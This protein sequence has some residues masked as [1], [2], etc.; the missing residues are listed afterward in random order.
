MDKTDQILFSILSTEISEQLF[1]PYKKSPNQV[2]KWDQLPPPTP[3]TFAIHQNNMPFMTIEDVNIRTFI[4]LSHT[5]E[6]MSIA[7]CH[8]INPFLEL[9]HTIV[10][11]SK[12][13]L[14]TQ[15]QCCRAND[16]VIFTIKLFS[17][18]LLR[19]TAIVS[20]TD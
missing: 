20:K 16:Y 11:V 19:T 17:E 13:R 18:L 9:L 2:R 12:N 15:F 7:T 1:W 5:D 10:N 3:Q 8:T 14:M 6:Y 4:E